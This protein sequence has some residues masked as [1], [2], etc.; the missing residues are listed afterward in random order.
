MKRRT[1]VLSAIAS[2]L[3]V[4]SLATLGLAPA[5]AAPSPAERSTSKATGDIALKGYGYGT[6]VVGGQVPAGSGMTAFTAIGCAVK[7]G[8][9]RTNEIAEADLQGNG[10]VSGVKTELSTRKVGD[11]VHSYSRN[12]TASVVLADSPLGTLSI[13]AITSLSHAWHDDKGFHAETATS[14]GKIV[15]TP[16]VGDPQELD[17]PT[18]NNP[19]EVPGLGTIYFGGSA[20]KVSDTGAI[21]RST[22]LRVDMTASS[23]TEVY[24]ARTTAQALSGVKHGR[25]GGFSAGT[26]VTALDG[27]LHSGRNPLSLMPCQGTNGE[28]QGKDD[29]N[30][31]LGGQLIAEGV[32]SRQYGERFAQRSVAWERGSIASLNLGAGQLVI[33]AVVGKAKAIRTSTGK[34]IRSTDGSTIGTITANG[35]P[36]SFPDTGVLEIPG[37][38][39]LEPHL[40][41]NVPGGVSVVALRVTLLDGT[42]AVIDLGVAKATIRSS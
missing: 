28:V 2:G 13:R 42:G 19:V 14:V 38:A 18:P 23:G 15:F 17:I 35:E 9:D 33:D 39:R 12:S 1:A 21:A 36:Q 8:I 29:A 24:I 5:S 34:L 41:T 26:E 25:F 16:P 10:T 22:A 7:T 30:A 40:V 4:S 27:T 11:A 20:K 6:R 31:D 32:S 3:L 37:V